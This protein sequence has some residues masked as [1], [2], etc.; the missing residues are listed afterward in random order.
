MQWNI[1]TRF[2]VLGLVVVAALLFLVP[3]FKVA[4][5]G[6]KGVELTPEEQAGEGWI[7]KPISLGLDLSGGVQLVYR[8]EVNEAVQSRL[9]AN[10]TAIRANL[11]DKKI[12]VR[13]ASATNDKKLVVTLMTDRYLEK[14]KDT[15]RTDMPSLVFV[16]EKKEGSSVSLWY[17]LPATEEAKVRKDA[18][19]QAV[20]NLRSRVDQFGVS[21][22]VIQKIGVDRILLQMPGVKDIDSVKKI[23]GKVAKLEFRFTPKMGS[24]AE[25]ITIKDRDGDPVKVEDEVQMSGDMVETASVERDQYGMPEISLK[26]TPEGSKAFARI[27]SE[28]LNRELAIIL[29][30]VLYSNPVIQSK[31]T[32]GRASITG[33]FDLK[34]ARE[35]ALVLK[36][37]ALPASLTVMSENNVG[38]TLGR[39]S[40]QSGAIAIVFG[41]ALILLFMVCYYKKSGIVAILTLGLN[42]IMVCAILSMFGATLTLPGIAGLALTIGMAVDANVIIFERIRDEIRNGNGRDVAVALGFE[43]A[44]SAIVDSNLTTLLTAILLYN[45]GTGP[46]RGFAVT[47]GIGVVT[48]LFCGTFASRVFFDHFGLKRSDGSLSI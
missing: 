47:L 36:A 15:I 26:M 28:G 17:E 48:T 34:E 20:E 24:D 14:A 22:P 37:G 9:Q 8:V 5:K 10:A 13:R 2:I 25:T 41:F 45:F 46:V 23:V 31:I 11:R 16:E 21:E 39:E 44:L 4:Y 1:K 33:H 30:G 42:M 18:V 6:L 12:A 35:L 32:G 38:P 43:K 19:E 7:T 40:I 27:S 29:D 3:T